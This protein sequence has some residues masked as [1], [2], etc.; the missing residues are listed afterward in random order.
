MALFGLFGGDEQEMDQQPV[1]QAPEQVPPQEGSGFGQGLLNILYQS[2]DQARPQGGIL[3]MD[4]RDIAAGARAMGRPKVGLESIYGGP[5][6]IFEATQMAGA[7]REA[8]PLIAAGKFGEAGQAYGADDPAKREA[9]SMKQAEM[10]FARKQEEEKARRAMI[11]AQAQAN[12]KMQ[13]ELMKPP[14]FSGEQRQAAAFGD[15]LNK[16]EGVLSGIQFRPTAKQ[17]AARKAAEGLPFGESLLSTFSSKERQQYEQ[18]KGQ[19]IAAA[20]RKESGAAIGKE[21]YDSFDKIYFPQPGD[22]AEVVAQKK[23]MRDGVADQMRF[24]SAGALDYMQTGARPG[25][26]APQAAK[27]APVAKPTGGKVASPKKMTRAEK[28][29]E[30]KRRRGEK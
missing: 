20:L 14:E 26:V 30:L 6:N 15:R 9:L 27:P 4:V 7:Q 16:A 25:M 23:T 8:A 13:Q 1:V 10:D 18:A 11:M 3:G 24:Q 29:A 28:I 17:E 21:E 2:P 22:T 12:L 5:Q 19:W